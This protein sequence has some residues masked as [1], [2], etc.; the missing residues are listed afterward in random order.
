MRLFTGSSLI[1]VPSTVGK[2][3]RVCFV[4]F[5]DFVDQTSSKS[6]LFAFITQNGALLFLPNQSNPTGFSEA[7]P[8]LCHEVGLVCNLQTFPESATGVLMRQECVTVR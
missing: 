1:E 5:A 7:P 6:Q 4:D 2:L 3:S 8:P